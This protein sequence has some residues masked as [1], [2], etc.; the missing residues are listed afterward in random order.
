MKPMVLLIVSLVAL[1]AVVNL[2]SDWG[3]AEVHYGGEDLDEEE[4]ARIKAQVGSDGVSD[5][6]VTGQHTS[7]KD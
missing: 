5:I 1:Q 7:V 6:D 2:I 3:K 4:I